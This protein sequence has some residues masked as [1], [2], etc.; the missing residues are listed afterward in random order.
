M[1]KPVLL[2]TIAA[3][4]CL[5]ALP[6]KADPAPV[7][8]EIPI[9]LLV[10]LSNGQ[11]LFAREENRRFVP[12]SVTKVMTAYTAFELIKAGELDLRRRVL[13]SRALE[14]QWYGEGSSM[15]LRAGDTPSIA[16]LLRG[17]TT[18]S[19][20][21]ASMALA[22]DAKGSLDGWLSAMNANAQRLG[23]ADSHF[24]SPNGFPDSGHTYTTAADLALLGKA[25]TIDHPGLYARFFGQRQLT[26]GGFT[27]QNH[28]PVTGQVEGGDGIKTGMTNEA[29]FTFLGSAMRGGRRLLVVVAGSPT[30]E[31][32]NEAARDLLE[33]GFTGFA[34]RRLAA[35]DAV[36]A[37]ALVQDGASDRVGLVAGDDLR[38]A[39]PANVAPESLSYAISYRGP[40]A[41]PFAAGDRLATLTISHKGE[42]LLET[43]LFASEAVAKA[44]FVRRIANAFAGWFA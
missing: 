30:A 29:G 11:T 15:F 16:D 21:D 24:G 33:W 5:A 38:V 10:D 3:A 4:L 18:V 40:V 43:P 39:L 14:R 19:G 42:A 13:Y 37:Q 12:A 36:I 28:D 9:V 8:D 26:W 7:S 17:I 6:A 35:G 44:G 23:M 41:A 31:E 25:L 34:S 20:N 32:R 1:H 27:Q 22:L 2:L